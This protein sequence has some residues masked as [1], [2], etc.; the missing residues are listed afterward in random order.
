MKI[1]VKNISK[2]YEPNTPE[3]KKALKEITFQAYEGDAIGIIGPTGSGKST[4]INCI[5]GLVSITEGEISYDDFNITPKTKLKKY[6]KIRKDV[7]ISYQNPDLQLF[8]EK[9]FDD[10]AMP[11]TRLKLSEKEINKRVLQ[12]CEHVHLPK[13]HL[14]KNTFNLSSGEKRKVII[15]SLLITNPQ[16]MI[17][18]EPT[19]FLDPASVKAFVAAIKELNKKYK[20][21]IFIVSH[22]LGV[23]KASTTR[24]LFLKEGII[25]AEGTTEEIL[26]RKKLLLGSKMVSKNYY[27]K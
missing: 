6:K 24:V 10:I 4:L 12:V 17:F 25:Y 14:T 21:T 5:A 23:I 20:K 11:L 9:V 2:V 18:D 3:E 13:T 1:L 15:A 7:S 16:V 19:A 27:E 26:S 22:H 8:K